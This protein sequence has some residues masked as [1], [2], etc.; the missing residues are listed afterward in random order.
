VGNSHNSDMPHTDGH[1]CAGLFNTLEEASGSGGHRIDCSTYVSYVLQAVGLMQ[2]RTYT[3]S[4]GGSDG[5]YG[6]FQ[7]YVITREEAGELQPGDIL[8]SDT[9][10]QINGEEHLQYNAGSGESIR[11]APYPEESPAFYTHVIRLPF[12]GTTTSGENYEGYE[13][14]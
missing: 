10:V 11:S 2:G 12:N 9:H 7:E 4:P 13:G 6:L 3:G 14:N 5:L 1:G 8:I